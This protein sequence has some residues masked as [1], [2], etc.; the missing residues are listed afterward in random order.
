MTDQEI[1]SSIRAG[2][3][4]CFRI[5]LDRYSKMSYAVAFR[6][7]KDHESTQDVVQDAFISAYENLSSF[8][9]E[10]KFS[11]WLYRIVVNKAL[12]YSNKKRFF[13]HIDSLTEC[14][15]END[16]VEVIENEENILRLALNEMSDKDRVVLE[17]FYYQEQSVKEIGA[18]LSESESNVKVILHRAR[19]KLNNSILQ[20][21][22]FASNE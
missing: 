12:A 4:N 11:T 7:V 19:K 8:K 13:D 18:I 9:G 1:V 15:E 3:K 5:L 16:E 22:N 10:S 6:I 21:R 17:L 14:I 20:L 2:D